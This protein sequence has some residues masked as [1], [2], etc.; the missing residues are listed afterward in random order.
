MKIVRGTRNVPGTAE[1]SSNIVA[2]E[3][4]EIGIDK[5][6]EKRSDLGKRG[7]IPRPSGFPSDLLPFLSFVILVAKL[8]SAIV[9]IRANFGEK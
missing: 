4:C 6:T 3:K 9:R 7:R 5:G 1:R 2:R 8:T